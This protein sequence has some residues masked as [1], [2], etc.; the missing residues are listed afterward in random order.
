MKQIEGLLHASN[1]MRNEGDQSADREECRR[2]NG[3]LSNHRMSDFDK[4]HRWD[5]SGELQSCGRDERIIKIPRPSPLPSPL[6]ASRLTAEP[7]V[8]L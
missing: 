2:F 7:K 8:E 4:L 3:P 5:T 6:F 1:G